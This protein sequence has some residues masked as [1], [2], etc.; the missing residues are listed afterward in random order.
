MRSQSHTLSLSWSPCR[1]LKRARRNGSYIFLKRLGQFNSN[2]SKLLLH[3]HFRTMDTV[4]TPLGTVAACSIST[5]YTLVY[6]GALYIH[7]ATRTTPPSS[8]D[9]PSTNTSAATPA[10][11]VKD[12]NSS[13]VIKARLTAVSLSTTLCLS[14]L[15]FLPLPPHT[16]SL[17]LLGL[18]LPSTLPQTLRL[19]LLPA[20]LTMSLFGGSI[21]VAGLRGILPGQRWYGTK[22][23][24]GEEFWQLVRNYGLVSTLVV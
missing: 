21:Y 16:S 1:D 14:S 17:A 7:P 20:A 9:S 13:S 19:I 2:Q 18:T 22:G 23:R 11:P 8:R 3:P 10:E 15:A 4:N 24:D 12:R 5:G 6:L